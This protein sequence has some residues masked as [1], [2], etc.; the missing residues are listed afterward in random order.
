MREHASKPY[1]ADTEHCWSTDT[2]YNLATENLDYG[3]EA[4]SMTYEYFP[5]VGVME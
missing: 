5:K 1:A 2:G 3:T 4:I